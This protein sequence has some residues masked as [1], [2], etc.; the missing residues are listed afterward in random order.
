M[1]I[2]LYP[3]YGYANARTKAMKSKLLD[4]NK[5]N[6]LL[7]VKSIEEVVE[8]LEESPY[9]GE[10]VELSTKYSDVELVNRATDANFSNTMKKLSRFI[11][12]GSSEL[13]ELVLEEW[14]IQNLKAL[15]ASKAT[16]ISATK[17]TTFTPEQQT[18]AII[19]SDASLDLKKTVKKLSFMG[20]GFSKVFR[21]IDREYAGKEMQDFRFMFKEL[22]DY[23]YSKLGKAVE[24]ERDPAVK[25]LLRAKID[26]INSMTVARLK[27][28]GVGNEEIKDNI[29]KSS[30]RNKRESM[31]LIEKETPLEVVEEITKIHKLSE[32]IIMYFKNRN[33]LVKLE[34][35]LERKL[36]Q[37]ALIISKVSVLSFAVILAYI[38]LKQQEIAFIKAIA[39]STQAGVSQELKELVFPVK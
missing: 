7:A 34:V 39:Y 11:P 24:N 29:V 17:L 14:T 30:G 5:I 4:Q 1:E 25:T 16:G 35:E 10:V 26:F 27:L 36:M 22:D 2:S 37:K 31:K 3:K 13:F 32:E 9:A 15:I 18:I 38:Y 12:N 28:A 20:Q 23:Y 6:Q 21:K 19:A 33:S 8:L